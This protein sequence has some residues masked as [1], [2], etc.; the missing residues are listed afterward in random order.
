LRRLFRQKANIHQILV[1]YAQSDK[2]GNLAKDLVILF[3]NA[4]YF[5]I[6]LAPEPLMRLNRDGG[7][8]IFRGSRRGRHREAERKNNG[9]YY[10]KRHFDLYRAVCCKS[11]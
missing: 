3:L 7:W 1:G 2:E 10:L 9:H 5:L 8:S 6:M 11:L 4:N